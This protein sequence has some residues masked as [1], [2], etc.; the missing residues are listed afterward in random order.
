MIYTVVYRYQGSR[1][2]VEFDNEP[3]ARKKIKGLSGTKG[4][5]DMTILVPLENSFDYRE[6]YE[7]LY[8]YVLTG[9]GIRNIKESE[10]VQ[11]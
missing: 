2:I 7:E 10:K 3:D 8:N 5:T 11:I 6:K 4:Y 9:A 1:T